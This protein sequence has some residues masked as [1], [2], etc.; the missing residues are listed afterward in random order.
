MFQKRKV[1]AQAIASLIGGQTQIDGNVR[2]SGGLRI[3]GTV[4]GSVTCSDDQGGMLVV[5]ETGNIRGEV[6]AAHLVVSGQIHGP[7]ISSELVELQPSARVMVEF[8]YRALEMHHGA[9]VHGQMIH[10][11]ASGTESPM[12]HDLPASSA[13]HA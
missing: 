1:K 9:V 6:V 7:V 8:R 11:D 5:S 4:N 2:F 12:Q 10:L 13:G 3:D